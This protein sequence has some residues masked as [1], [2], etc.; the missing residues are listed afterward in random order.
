MGA[1]KSGKTGTKE[2]RMDDRGAGVREERKGKE[3]L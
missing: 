1:G 3:N 2:R